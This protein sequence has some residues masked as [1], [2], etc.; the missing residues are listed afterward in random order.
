MH[1]F[2]KKCF[3]TRRRERPID[4]KVITTRKFHIDEPTA[5]AIGKF[6]SLHL[7]HQLILKRL[8]KEASSGLKT[9]VF[10]FSPSPEVFFEKRK[11]RYVLTEQE[12]QEFLEKAGIDY[13][14]LFPFNKQTAEIGPNVFLSEI[15]LGQLNMNVLVAGEDLSFGKGGSG[16]VAFM[17]TKSAEYDFKLCVC[18]K[19]RYESEVI[20]ASLVRKT[21]LNGNMEKCSVLLDRDYEITGIVEKGNQLGRTLGVPTC[22]ISAPKEKLLP[23]RGVYFT[24]VSVDGGEY[25]G[26]TNVGTKPTVSGNGKMGIETHILQF[27]KEIYDKKITLKFQHFHRPEKKFKD[28]QQLKRQL[29]KDIE[30]ALIF[31]EKEFTIILD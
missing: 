2:L 9:V 25:L 20:S 28:V 27:D 17:E 22:N 26:V 11:R 24:I 6:D 15:L 16:N 30:Q 4:M 8:K 29:E 23:P 3:F 12:K 13:Y 5:V 14:I 7:G 19:L 18:P 21:V 10:S 31:L 1:L